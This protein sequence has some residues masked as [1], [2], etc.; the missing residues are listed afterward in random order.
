M[1]CRKLTGS[2]NSASVFKA[3]LRVTTYLIPLFLLFH[4]LGAQQQP[5]LSVDPGETIEIDPETG[6]TVARGNVRVDGEGYLLQSREIE[7]DSETNRAFVKGNVRLG[8]G[9]MRV[10]ASEATY[11]LEDK[12]IQT[13]LLRLGSAPFY[14][15]GRKLEGSPDN[16]TL[17]SGTIYFNEP[18]FYSLN[19]KASELNYNAET[20]IWEMHHAIFRI[21]PVPFFYLPYYSQKGFDRPPVN[22]TANLGFNNNLGA[23]GQNTIL[24]NRW[25]SFRPGALLDFYSKRGVLVGPAANYDFNLEDQVIGGELRAG[26]ISDSGNRGLDINNKPIPRERY[27]IDLRHKQYVGERTEITGVLNWWSDSDVL[28]DFRPNWF[29][30]NQQPDNF[31]EG[32]YMGDNFYLSAFTRFR[33]NNFEVIQERL[34]E[35]RFDMV[36]NEIGE[37]TVFHQLNLS[38]AILK[39]QSLTGAPTLNSNRLDAYYGINRPFTL[40][41][42]LTFNPVAGTRVTYYEKTL[43]GGG[44]FTRMLGQVGFDAEAR[45]YGHWKYQ[46]PFWGIDDIRH[47]LRPVVQ[48]RYIPNAQQGQGIIPP[49]D[50]SVFNT[51]PPTLDLGRKRNVDD[52]YE[53]NV[54]R[55]GLQNLVQTRHPSYGSHDLLSLNM[56]QDFRFSRRPGFTMLSD[57]WTNL[58]LSPVPWLGFTLFTRFDSA[59]MTLS[60][61]RTRTRLIDGGRWAAFFS[62]DNLR[63]QID[64]YF[65]DLEY[66]F[67]ERY[68]AL[69]RWRYDARLNELTEQIYGLRTFI[70]NSWEVEYQISYRQGTKNENDFGFNVRF[71]LLS[72]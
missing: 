60:E 17:Q 18:D 30:D 34:P 33:P 45:F 62:T 65:I 53:E 69:G 6:R 47:V 7:V 52:L 3:A 9:G 38:A 59:S 51:S 25:Q 4:H 49:I 61:I 58:D 57:F 71:K 41:P 20:E 28:R 67:S 39:E 63:S 5:A 72:F 54:L 70:G 21:G 8:Y 12:T 42:W 36:P 32:V 2:P 23:Y 22:L 24:F 19:I 68:L 66:R 43:G 56:Y 48:Y 14:V 13:G 64:Q 10:V 37:T 27:F 1:S 15:Q 29:M 35:L 16:V 11:N 55:V 31:L 40:A 50:D 26:W 44:P 46:N